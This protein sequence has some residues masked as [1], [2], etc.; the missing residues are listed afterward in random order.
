[1]YLDHDSLTSDTSEFYSTWLYSQ[2]HVILTKLEGKSNNA[3]YTFNFQINTNKY[4]YI[5]S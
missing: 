2:K 5:Y 4:E 1:M 3:G